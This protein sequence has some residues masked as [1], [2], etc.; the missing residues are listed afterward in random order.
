MEVGYSEQN[1]GEAVQGFLS[2][3][4]TAGCGAR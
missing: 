4:N 3:I 1:K 2:R